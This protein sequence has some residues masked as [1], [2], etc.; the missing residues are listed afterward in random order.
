[1]E[2]QEHRKRCQAA[3][4]KKHAQADHMKEF[5]ARDELIAQLKEKL[6]QPSEYNAMDTEALPQS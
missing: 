6:S 3:R 4:V 2:A 5:E 1:M